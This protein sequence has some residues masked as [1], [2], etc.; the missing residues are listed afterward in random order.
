MVRD[1]NTDDAVGNGGFIG[2]AGF[3]NN[4]PRTLAG[5]RGMK[6]STGN[7]FNGNLAFYT[8]QN[9]VADLRW[10]NFPWCK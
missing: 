4:V 5:I 9:G 7:N 10:I 6:S 2:F 1:S 3:V 8:R